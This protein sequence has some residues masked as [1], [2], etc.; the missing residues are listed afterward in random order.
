MGVEYY[1]GLSH[2]I[3]FALLPSPVGRFDLCEVLGTGTYGEVFS[4][5]CKDTG[6]TVAVKVMENI[7]DNL[8][9]IDAE[10]LVLRDLCLHPNIPSFHGLYLKLGA[11][12]E[13]DQLWI[14]MEVSSARGS[15]KKPQAHATPF[16]QTY[17]TLV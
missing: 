7:A 13:E 3:N 11:K 4:A 2:H 5:K 1:N 8:E 9:E 16:P 6:R 10:F 15:A 14:V 17:V 12:R